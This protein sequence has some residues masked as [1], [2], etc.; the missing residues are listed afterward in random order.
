MRF[1]YDLNF[2]DLI[3]AAMRTYERS[4]VLRRRMRLSRLITTLTLVALVVGF[5][6]HSA[7]TFSLLFVAPLGATLGVVLW[8]LLPLVYRDQRFRFLNDYYRNGEGRNLV[9]HY[10]LTVSEPGITV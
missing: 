3:A 7:G 5:M 2:D 1:E 8:I 4:A 9:G 10:S 6:S